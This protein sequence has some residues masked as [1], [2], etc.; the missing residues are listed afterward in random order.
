MPTPKGLEYQFTDFNF[1]WWEDD[2]GS[3]DSLDRLVFKD[4]EPIAVKGREIIATARKRL[5]AL[6]SW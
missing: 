4:Q 5:A 3:S 2:T 1:T 6:G